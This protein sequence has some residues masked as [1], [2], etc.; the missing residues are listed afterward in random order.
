M[1]EN[2]NVPSWD[3]SIDYRDWKLVITGNIQPGVYFCHPAFQTMC[4][5]LVVLSVL[6]S[7][8]LCI[9]STLL[10]FTCKHAM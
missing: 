2:E 3:H 1:E 4:T 9:L 10:A 8:P 6:Y 7:D 5:Y